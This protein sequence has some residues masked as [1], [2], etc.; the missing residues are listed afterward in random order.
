SYTIPIMEPG[1][2][3]EF[4]EKQ[5]LERFES[6]KLK[7]D[8]DSAADLL[9]ELISCDPGKILLDAN[10]AFTDVEDCI[11][12]LESIRRIPLELVEQPLPSRLMDEAVYL[13]KYSPFKLF[14]DEAVTHDPDMDHVVAAYHGINM[15]LMKTGGYLQGVRILKEARKRGLRTM[16]GCMVETTLGISSALTLTGLADYTDLDSFL[17]L[18]EEPFRIL[19]E[20]SGKLTFQNPQIQ[21]MIELD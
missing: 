10:E 15:K 21:G 7:I 13:K 12:F 16:I 4:Y 1:L 17:L 14:A 19:Q 3:R 11:R 18:K 20:K 9:H 6:I 8:R 2:V 5:R